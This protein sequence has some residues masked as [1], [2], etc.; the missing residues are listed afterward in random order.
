MLGTIEDTTDYDS[1]LPHSEVLDVGGL[2]VRVLTL[3]RLIRVKE[4]LTRPKD[5]LM[6]TILQA[7]LKERARKR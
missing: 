4:Q 3:E 6:L 5:R 1:L 2:P 7:T